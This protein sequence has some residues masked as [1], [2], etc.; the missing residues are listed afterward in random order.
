MRALKSL[1]CLTLLLSSSAFAGAWDVGAFDNDDALDWVWELTESDDL[2]PLAQA[3]D[4]VL[5][6]PRYIEAP[7]ASIA[8]A[9]A[10]VLAALR[11][12]PLDVLPDEVTGWVEGRR[13]APDSRMTEK[14]INAIRMILD[15]EVSELAQLWADS[16][17]LADDWRAGVE[18]LLRRLQ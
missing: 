15:E 13:L 14:A 18:D 2:A 16:P 11:G 3:F 10:E 5:R 4:E 1:L 8:I 9:A 7:S 17:E 12:N 6:S